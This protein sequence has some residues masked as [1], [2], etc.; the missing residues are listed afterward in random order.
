[1]PE[2]QRRADMSITRDDEPVQYDDRSYT[3]RLEDRIHE[4][5][6]ERAKEDDELAYKYEL[7]I[8]QLEL[9]RM[10]LKDLIT[11]SWLSGDHKILLYTIRQIILD[12]RY[13]W[14]VPV[15]IYNAELQNKTGLGKNTI[16]R[17]TQEL[18]N[19]G[20]ITKET[21]GKGREQRTWYSL[22]GSIQSSAKDIKVNA[23]SR[24][25]G[26]GRC[27]ECGSENIVVKKTYE[28][29]DCGHHWKS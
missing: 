19:V 4:L 5:E 11:N 13:D 6:V 24:N 25:H 18:H 2:Q 17:L 10:W 22:G 23:R 1:M 14:T 16:I 8:N 20:L 9:E 26:G 3:Q 27:C 28:C 12:L 21:R 15:L 29:L 7:K